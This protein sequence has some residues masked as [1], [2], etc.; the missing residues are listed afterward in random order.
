MGRVVPNPQSCV[1]AG[2]SWTVGAILAGTVRATARLSES[3]SDFHITFA[4]MGWRPGSR[5]ASCPRIRQVAGPASGP[6]EGVQ[7]RS[8]RGHGRVAG[9]SNRNAPRTALA[10]A[11]VRCGGAPRW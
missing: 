8:P 9:R 7:L 5:L 10:G 1:E 4:A 6:G 3:H 11:M 2:P